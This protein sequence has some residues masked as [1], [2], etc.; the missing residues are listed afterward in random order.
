MAHPM[1]PGALM[2]DAE[3]LDL[4][5]FLAGETA[6]DGAGRST[7]VAGLTGAATAR[8]Q[9]EHTRPAP[10]IEHR[11]A[12]SGANTPVA[13]MSPRRLLVCLTVL[14]W[15]ER[16]LARRTGRHQTEVRR[17]VSGVSPVRGDVAAWLETLTAFH[18]SYPA[19]R[20][21]RCRPEPR[22]PTP[23]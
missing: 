13:P 16:E 19:P 11:G 21:R 3:Q 4:I 10:V 1:L 7:P 8:V 12:A 15:P 2:R 17:W 23:R 22:R 18:E 9:N 6:G 5:A 20:P 14:G